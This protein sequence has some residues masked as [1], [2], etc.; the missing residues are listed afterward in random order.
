LVSAPNKATAEKGEE[1]EYSIIELDARTGK[2]KLI[3]EPV[4]VKERGGKFIENEG[5]SVEVDKGP[6]L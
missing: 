4:Y 3:T 1:K 6:L 5:R 2:V